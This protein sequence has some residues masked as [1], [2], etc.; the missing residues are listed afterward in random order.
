MTRPTSKFRHNFRYLPELF[1]NCFVPSKTEIHKIA[2]AV[3]SP[4][5]FVIVTRF[6]VNRQDAVVFKASAL[7]QAD[8]N[9]I[10]LWNCST[11]TLKMIFTASLL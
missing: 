5:A 6:S 2:Q 11:T 9:F 8:L 4:T 3:A 10:F 7:Q 1:R